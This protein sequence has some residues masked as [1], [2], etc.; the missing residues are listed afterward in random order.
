MSR[1]FDK[2]FEIYRPGW[3]GSC[4]CTK[5]A[6]KSRCKY[7]WCKELRQIFRRK[8]AVSPYVVRLYVEF[9]VY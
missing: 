4:Y 5:H 1:E 6:I 2:T 7:L 3:H 9:F 8:F